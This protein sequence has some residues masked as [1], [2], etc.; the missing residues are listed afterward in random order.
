M[1]YPL[2]FWSIVLWMIVWSVVGSVVTPRVFLKKDLDISNAPLTGAFVGAATGP[3]GL[4][5]LWQI[6][7]MQ[8][9]RWV[10]ISAVLALAILIAAFAIADP[11]N[12]CVTSGGF[13]A[14]QIY[15]PLLHGIFTWRTLGP[16]QVDP[17]LGA[18]AL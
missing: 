3:L 15:R 4:I 5:P 11:D 16:G 17:E 9:Q 18:H 12:V 10:L 14:S 13:V 6:A 2:F 8:T 7:P 1:D